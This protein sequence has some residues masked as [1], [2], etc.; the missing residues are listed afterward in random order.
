MNPAGVSLFYG[1]TDTKSRYEV[2]PAPP[3]P[4]A[5]IPPA[6]YAD[7]VGKTSAIAPGYRYDSRND[8][9]DPTR[10]RRFSRDRRRRGRRGWNGWRRGSS[11]RTPRC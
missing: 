3:P 1:F 10:G 9:F 8:P 5:G 7:Y 11:T 4:G 2:F 6:A